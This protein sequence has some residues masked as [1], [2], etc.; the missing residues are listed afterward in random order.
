MVSTTAIINNI[1]VLSI[2]ATS[3][4]LC[5]DDFNTS[6]IFVNAAKATQYNSAII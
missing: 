1:L 5:V 4:L 3:P 6:Y 2:P